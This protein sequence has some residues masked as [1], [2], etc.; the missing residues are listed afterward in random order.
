MG[1]VVEEFLHGIW[2]FDSK[3]WRTLPMLVFRPGKLTREYIE[4]KRARYIA[5]LALFL[6]SVFLMFFVFGLMSGINFNDADFKVDPKDRQE[7]IADLGKEL[8]AAEAEL[9]KAEAELASAQGDVTAAR[10]ARDLAKAALERARTAPLPGAPDA[11]GDK[12][13]RWQDRVAEE[14]RLNP[15]MVNTGFKPLDDTMRKS[16][17][18]PD[19]A[20][21]KVQQKAYKLSF[22]LVPLSLPMLWLLFAFKRGV[23]MY[24]HTVFALYSLSFMSL[25]LVAV[26]LLEEAGAP[27]PVYAS[28]G[29]LAPPIHMY[30]QLK[31]GYGLGWFGALWRTWALSLGAIIVLSVY[32]LFIVVIGLID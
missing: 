14:A 29:A 1:H 24:D 4:G 12:K 27:V 6:L 21:Y 17:L 5:P 20:L 28:L 19:L 7:A 9:S 3:A 16:L 13:Q 30:A 26:V 25:L 31:G 8:D 11:K 2:H 23:N 18:N 22:L 32:F 10:I 15:K